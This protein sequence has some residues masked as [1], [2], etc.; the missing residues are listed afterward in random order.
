MKNLI[1]VKNLFAV[2]FLILCTTAAAQDWDRVLNLKGLWKFSIG[3]DKKWAESYNDDSD[4]ETVRVPSYWEEE[5]FYGYNGYAWYRKE[6]DMNANID[7]ESVYLSLGYIDD[8][9]EVYLN[10]KLIGSSGSFPPNFKTAYNAERKYPV[11]S[12]YFYR[13]KENVIA[14]RVYDPT[15]GGGINA[16]DIGIY[17]KSYEFLVDRNLEGEWKFITGDDEKF[18][19]VKFDDTKW[20]QIFVPGY[21]ET[22]GYAD[23]NGVAWYRKSFT[24]KKTFNDDKLVLLLGKIDD[25]DEVYLNGQLIGQTGEF[26]ENPNRSK[27]ENEWSEFRGY[28]FPARLLNL[29][30]ENII[31]VRVY[32]GYINGGIYEGPIGITTQRNY[33]KAWKRISK[34]KNFWDVFWGD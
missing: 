7:D 31:A 4:W 16:G 14:V 23:Y 21:W 6:F 17:V 29:N 15:L 24:I 34:K 30:G 13:G 11:P 9:D 18:K 22:Q 20:D 32:D 12:K 5:G 2:I 19:D 25:I 10:G 28:L 3:D 27:F 8:V 1:T 26:S 33:Q